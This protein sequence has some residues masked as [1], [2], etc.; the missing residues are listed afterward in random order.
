[1]T[2]RSSG[3]P[4]YRRS[5]KA[6]ESVTLALAGSPEAPRAV[7]FEISRAFVPKRLGLSQDRR[8]LGLLSTESR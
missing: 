2:A 6:G 5:L 7:I 1:L 4:D 8:E 3:R